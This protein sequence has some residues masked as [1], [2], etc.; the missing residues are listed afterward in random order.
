MTKTVYA[1]EMDKKDKD[2]YNTWTIERIK[3]A[4]SNG[5][6]TI[7]DFN[8]YMNDNKRYCNFKILGV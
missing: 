7:K 5:H 4:F 6:G 1:V 8:R 3:K 2:N